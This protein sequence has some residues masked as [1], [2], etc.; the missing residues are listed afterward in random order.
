MFQGIYL[1]CFH[2]VSQNGGLCYHFRNL[3]GFSLIWPGFNSSTFLFSVRSAVSTPRC[4][5]RRE[6]PGEGGA[7]S[8]IRARFAWI[9][10]SKLQIRRRWGSD[11]SDL[12]LPL[13]IR[14]SVA[15]EFGLGLS[16]WVRKMRSPWVVGSSPRSRRAFGT[17]AARCIN[18]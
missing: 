1:Q 14:G 16:S 4:F 11:P 6:Q 5:Q 7:N 3:G 17:G 15:F 18:P 9:R 12:L 8:W 10:A 2:Y 13:A